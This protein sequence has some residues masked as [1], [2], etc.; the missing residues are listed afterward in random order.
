MKSPLAAVLW[1]SL[2]AFQVFGANTEVGKTVFT[3]LLTRSAKKLW[4]NET[5]TF[6]KPVSTGPDSEAD[7]RCK[8]MKLTSFGGSAPH[9]QR[10]APDVSFKTLVQYGLPVSPHLAAQTSGLAI[11]SNETLLAQC[12]EFAADCASQGKGWLFL[13]TAGGVHSPAPTGTT[14]AELYMPL[15]IPV[16][17]IGD[18]R[19]GGISQTISAFESLKI[20]G[21]DVESVL[22]F[23]DGKYD[24][25]SYLSDYFKEHHDIPVAGM[26]PPP[27]RGNSLDIDVKAMT[28]YYDQRSREPGTQNILSLLSRR[29]EERIARLESMPGKALESI[30]FPFTQHKLIPPEDVM[31]IDSAHGDYFQTLSPSHRNSST[32]DES[33]IR[34]SFDGS[35]S[36]WTQGLGH[37]N[38]KLTLAA[39]YAAGRYGHVIFP[40][41]VQEPALAL[42]ETLLDGM[43]SDR[44]S[45]VFFSDN[46]STGIEVGL[47]MGLRAAKLRYGWDADEKLGVLGLKGSY[48]G[49]TIGALDS[50]EPSGFNA[51]IE[52][53]DSKGYWFDYPV[54]MCVDG[55]WQVRVPDD[56]R[57]DLGT[58]SGFGSLRDIFDIQ[59]REQRGDHIIYEKFIT[60]TLEGLQAQGR[61][62][63][64]LILEPVILGAGGMQ[65]A[66]PLFQRALV[67]VVRRSAHLFSKSGKPA[68]P[69]SDDPNPWTGL[70]IIFDE[71]FTGLYRVGRFTSS[72]FLG[73][74]ADI[75]V[76]AKLL[77]GGLV[78]LC[79]TL[80]SES[81]F[82]V[83]LSDEKTDALLHGHSYTAHPVGCQVALESVKEMQ[84]M[85]QN[86]E[87]DWA[88]AQG[89]I[90]PVQ[91]KDG[92]DGQHD[93]VWSVWP[94]SLVEDLSRNTT[95]VSGVWAIGSV[96]AIH[97]KDSTGWSGY[98]SN[99]ALGLRSL[100]DQGEVAA[101]GPWN[102]HCRVL[103]NVLY[104]MAGQKTTQDSI[105]QISALLERGLQS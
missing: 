95:R 71:V 52:W 70:P 4:E 48:H 12:R 37:G 44:L 67:N 19:L 100:L 69:T 58:D 22:V 62:F 15:R 72:S 26:T 56:L 13:E 34:A 60:K 18:Y 27:E 42:T 43:K 6:L 39:A 24:N 96:I 21:Y 31:V 91:S 82:K 104:V 73:V 103:G 86:G 35:A 85:E 61:R 14:Q 53:Y 8:S 90:D 101:N 41:A 92:N 38:T 78:P 75:S 3:T 17:L 25:F 20:R 80:A 76:H 81:I 89:W 63:G 54:V 64:S 16:V 45:R 55:V 7:D 50:A 93:E 5:V 65:L 47:K 87:W 74:N 77:T 10:F 23:K 40:S 33:L 57:E 30:W 2:R 79:T 94:R 102:V 66:D 105:S 32:A 97:M 1:R 59:G 51:K 29:H 11:S 46:G 98:F 68:T 36:W 99:A 28:E 84:K 9:I 83:F 49:D 88:K